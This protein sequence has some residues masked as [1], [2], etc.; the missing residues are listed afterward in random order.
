MRNHPQ[1][2]PFTR[3]LIPE[4]HLSITK[5]ETRDHHVH[6]GTIQFELQHTILTGTIKDQRAGKPIRYG[7][8]RTAGATELF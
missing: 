8:M 4:K 3:N 1:T 6:D 5:Q 7:P 2:V